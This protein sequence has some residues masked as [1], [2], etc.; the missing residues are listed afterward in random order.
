MST[1]SNKPKVFPDS[2]A[3]IPQ[4][5]SVVDETKTMVDQIYA[6]ALTDTQFEAVEAMR[7]RTENQLRE[8]NE[9]LQNTVK[10]E[11][12]IEKKTTDDTIKY[13]PPMPPKPPINNI[14]K[15][16]N[17]NDM[18]GYIET[19]SQPDF[20]T[21]CDL[22]PLP[23]GG[24]CYKSKKKNIMVSYLTTADENI[25]TSPNLLASGHF[26]EILINRK[27]LDDS[28]RY[29]DL[30]PGDRDAI[31]IWLRA[32]SFGDNYPVELLDNDNIP[33]ESSIN[34]SE[35]KMIPLSVDPDENGLFDYVV[36]SL[37]D[38]LK[39][40]ILTMGEVEELVK[41]LND[42]K[43]AGIPVNNSITYTLQRQIV[44]V[45]N[46]TDKDAIIEFVRKLRIS[47]NLKLSEFIST[48]DCGVDLTINVGIPGGGSLT[49]FLP[50]NAKF[51]W[52][53]A[54]I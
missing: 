44:S 4:K 10:A 25:L 12:I 34:L 35:L 1:N 26:L 18:S 36:P 19:L 15:D 30:I 6:N 28:I 38:R 43:E 16:S 27:I 22:I 53:N 2:D 48:L 5:S 37:G 21:A 9:K 24:K 3:N 33:F 41:I 42:E 17:P 20:N 45:N 46:N 13:I 49:T 23:S 50:L 40:K 32:T 7:Q 54:R 47:D 39:I 51:F 31:L 11:T 52:P 14:I 29:K 8:R